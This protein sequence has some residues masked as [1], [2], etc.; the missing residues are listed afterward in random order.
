MGSG[1]LFLFVKYDRKNFVAC[2]RKFLLSIACGFFFV[3]FL[4][5][6]S[7]MCWYKQLL[8]RELEACSSQW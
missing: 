1:E 3:A 5:G 4:K 8:K 6:N 2:G 7:S